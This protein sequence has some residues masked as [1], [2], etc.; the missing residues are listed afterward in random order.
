[1][2]WFHRRPGWYI[3]ESQAT[4]ESTYW[5]RREI[6][7]ACGIGGFGLLSGALWGGCVPTSLQPDGGAEEGVPERRQPTSRPVQ[8]DTFT[9]GKEP[10]DNYPSNAQARSL[11]PAK[12][13]ELYKVSERDVTP[14]KAAQAYNNYYEFS[15][16]KDQV[17]KQTGSFET[18]PWQLQFG[19]LFDKSVKMDVED[20][21]K[22]IGLE[23]RVY[24]FRCVEAWSMT[25]PWVGFPL[26]K[27]IKLMGYPSS[28]KYVRFLTAHKPDQMPGIEHLSN[29]TFPY[30]EALRLDEAMNEL[31]FV[32]TGVY[33]HPLT[34][35]MGAPIRLIIPWKYGYKSI[36]SIVSMELT[37]IQPKTFWNTAV[38]AEY[39]FYSNVNPEKPHPRWSQAKERLLPDFKEIDTKPYNGYAEDVSSLYTGKED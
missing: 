27:L 7:K 16:V 3:P 35:Q 18:V 25:V 10:A 31:A 15:V 32:A 36:K 13:N 34:R 11:Y 38:P 29:Y 21:I 4:D 9:V 12:R 20:I 2:A 8:K 19:G 30:H 24:R 1:M 17:W 14:E 26:S 5:K 37:S 39:G 22:Q 6:V 28:A 33:G 23:E